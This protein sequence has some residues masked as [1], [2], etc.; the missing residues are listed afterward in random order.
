MILLAGAFIITLVLTVFAFLAIVFGQFSELA[1]R[2][3]ITVPE[4]LST[5]L[6]VAVLT[7]MLFVVASPRRLFFIA[8][9]FNSFLDVLVN[10]IP[11]LLKGKELFTL[12][13]GRG[14]FLI[15]FLD[16][17]G[18][19][20]HIVHLSSDFKRVTQIL[21]LFLRVWQLLNFD[22]GRKT[23]FAELLDVHVVQIQ[24]RVVFVVEHAGAVALLFALL[25]ALLVCFN[26]TLHFL[27]LARLQLIV[28]L[29]A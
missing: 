25:A 6:L 26:L 11:F 2:V 28:D 24:A 10:S 4:L 9:D 18:L 16:N 29:G 15:I 22:G 17:F 14:T 27:E 1:S 7:L 8:D 21:Q 13:N 12:K 5:D 3:I 23:Q 20:L 19:L